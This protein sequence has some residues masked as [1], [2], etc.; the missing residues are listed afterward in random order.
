MIWDFS[1][2]SGKVNCFYPNHLELTFAFS[3]GSYICS[4]QKKYLVLYSFDL[5]YQFQRRWHAVGRKFKQ[6]YADKEFQI[7]N[8]HFS[9]A[10]LNGHEIMVFLNECLPNKVEESLIAGEPKAVSGCQLSTSIRNFIDRKFEPRS[11]SVATSLHKGRQ[12]FKAPRVCGIGKIRPEDTKW[13]FY[14]CFFPRPERPLTIGRYRHQ[15]GRTSCQKKQN[16]ESC[17]GIF[18]IK[19]AVSIG[20]MGHQHYR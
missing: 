8:E 1:A 13:K 5:R 12:N 3:C 15:K 10:E 9:L 11:L 7:W 4:W 18:S 17:T 16:Q 6:V 20:W 14:C 2:I 19:P